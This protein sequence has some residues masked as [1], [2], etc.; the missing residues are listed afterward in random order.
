MEKIKKMFK[1]VSSKNG[2]YSVGLTVLVLVI[3]VLVNLVAGQLPES[4]R[5]IDISDNGIYEIS[6]VSEEI[7]DELD[8]EVKLTVVADLDSV[9][10]RIETFVKKYA[11]LSKKIDL[12]WIDSVQHPS[13]L[14]K[15]NTEGDIINVE[16]E[17]T[18]KSTQIAFDDIIKYEIGRAHV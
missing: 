1:S 16:C 2:T 9:D 7:L 8:K 13:A 4:M 18:G 5:N 12:E 6:E 14:Q 10:Q 15:Y 11:A 3:A 17:E